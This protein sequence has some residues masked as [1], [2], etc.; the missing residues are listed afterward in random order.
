MNKF[1]IGL[2]LSLCSFQPLANAEWQ[3]TINLGAWNHDPSGDFSYL[4]DGIDINDGLGLERDTGFT[5]GAEIRHPIAY[6]PNVGIDY[7]QV[8]LTGTGGI[9]AAFGDSIFGVAVFG[10]AAPEAISDRL[11]IDQ[12]DVTL[13]YDLVVEGVDVDLGLKV[14]FFDGKA[15]ITSRLDTT[16]SESKSFAA[17]IPMLYGKAVWGLPLEG[18][19]VG[20]KGAIINYDDSEVSDYEV[21]VN[22]DLPS[23]LGIGAGWR[24]Q[25][26][27]LDDIDGIDADVK[28]NG[29]FLNGHF[30]F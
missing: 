4:G 21:F 2:V 17:P 15:T 14:K 16:K 27:Q 5:F 18:L 23:G 29:P 19:S 22:Y 13:S 25:R 8:D 6:L 11:Q 7:T 10:T 24:G 9:A 26:F 28:L 1:S 20:A 12:T 3:G 30:G